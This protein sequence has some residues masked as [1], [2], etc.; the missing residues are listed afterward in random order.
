MHAYIH[1][2]IHTYILYVTGLCRL[3]QRLGFYRQ[4][5]S[6]TS[7][8]SNSAARFLCLRV[9][10]KTVASAL[11]RNDVDRRTYVC[12]HPEGNNTILNRRASDGPE[13]RSATETYCKCSG[14]NYTRSM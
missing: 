4:H 8:C 3:Q 10:K 9:L 1:A 5:T 6:Q 14:R 11:E 13:F 12:L 7:F 2:Y